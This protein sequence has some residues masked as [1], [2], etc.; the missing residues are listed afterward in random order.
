MGSLIPLDPTL[1]R[2]T[3]NQ[4]PAASSPLPSPNILWVQQTISPGFPS[5]P[6]PVYKPQHKES[7]LTQPQ[8][9][10]ANRQRR[11]PSD[12]ST[13]V[14]LEANLRAA[15]SAATD[16]LSQASPKPAMLLNPANI[17]YEHTSRAG[18]ESRQHT[19][20]THSENLEKKQ[21][22]RKKTPNNNKDNNKTRNQQLDFNKPHP[23]GLD[24]S[25][26]T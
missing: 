15:P 21:K 25:I 12:F 10:P 4:T 11:L 20:N 26:R 14:P 19:T 9:T 8:A 2:T 7:T 22:S 13:S 23:I 5:P 3:C 17:P 6:V 24:A 18:Q 1:R 16:Y